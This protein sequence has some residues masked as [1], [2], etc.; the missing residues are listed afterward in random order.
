LAHFFDSILMKSPNFSVG[1]PPSSVPYYSN[2]SA[3]SGISGL[4]TFFSTMY[5]SYQV[6]FLA[7]LNKYSRS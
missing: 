6:Y 1:P 5:P 2:V 4:S 7:S 3:T